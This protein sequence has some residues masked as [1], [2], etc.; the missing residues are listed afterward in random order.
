MNKTP[1]KMKPSSDPISHLKEAVRST[2]LSAQI[3]EIAES[4]NRTQKYLQS[5]LK[6]PNLRDHFKKIEAMTVGLPF[7]DTKHLETLQKQLNV[8]VKQLTAGATASDLARAAAL[9]ITAPPADISQTKSTA[10]NNT[11]GRS[12]PTPANTVA[13]ARDIGLLVRAAR[14][15]QNM[16]QQRFADLAGVGRRFVSE[17]ENGK[18]TLEFDKVLQVAAAAGVDLMARKR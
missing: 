7:P 16:T 6:L 11:S 10:P 14:E 12:F 15:A 5:E 2:D 4:H 1:S 8:T 13:S 3:K 17:L 18:A 9:K